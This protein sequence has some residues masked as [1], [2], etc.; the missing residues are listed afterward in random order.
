MTDNKRRWVILGVDDATRDAIT[1]YAG[2][3]QLTIGQ[4]LEE[5]F[6]GLRGR[7][8]IIQ[9]ARRETAASETK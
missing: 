3:R 6:S 7:M 1:Q 9:R 2:L 5:E 4:V 8:E